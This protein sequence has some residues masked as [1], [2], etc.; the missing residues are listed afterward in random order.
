MRSPSKS[1][2]ARSGAAY[3][4]S[5]GS[6]RG[7][8][9]KDALLQAVTDDLEQNGLAGFTL[10]R[11]A[12][13]AGTTHKVLLY[14]FEN[15]DELLREAVIELRERRIANTLDA[16]ANAQQADTLAARVSA[17]WPVVADPG[18]GVRALDQAVGLALF[19]PGRY[20]ALAHESTSQY[21][22]AFLSICPPEWTD[23]R[24]REVA[25]LLIATFRG[26]LVGWLTNG[27]EEGL[28]AGLQALVRMM[29]REEAAGG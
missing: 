19:D 11:A 20:A 27:D 16:L 3:A 15:A 1:A 4:R 23:R 22:P 13:A 26:L 21:L 18:S 25:E 28:Q 14:H 29:E 7:Q 10:R 24:K 17:I 6:P 9:R 8:A 5:T 2:G 12:R